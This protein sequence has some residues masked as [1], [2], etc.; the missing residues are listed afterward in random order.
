MD[1]VQ[2]LADMLQQHAATQQRQ[3]QAFKDQCQHWRDSI[4]A[5][6]A[7]IETWLAP[8][9]ERQLLV[10]E[11]TPWVATSSTYP[12]DHS[13]FISESLAII[14]AQRRVELVPQVMGQGGAMVIAVAGLTSDRHGSISIVKDSADGAWFWRKDRGT[15][16]AESSQL[17]AHFFAQQLQG[18]IPK[19]RD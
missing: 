19:S 1:E 2:Q 6:F 10:I 14:L 7:Q 18:L 3:Q 16:E 17:D 11:R 4:R 5:L 8:L 9:T 12:S 13:P 15:K